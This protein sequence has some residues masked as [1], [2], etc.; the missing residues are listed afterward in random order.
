M[1]RQRRN[2][3]GIEASKFN[4]LATLLLKALI[5]S[6]SVVN[7]LTRYRNIDLFDLTE[8]VFLGIL[9]ERQNI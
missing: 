6:K 7:N 3:G 2:T 8:L 5:S 9:K 4:S 1:L